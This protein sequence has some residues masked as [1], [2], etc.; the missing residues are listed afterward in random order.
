MNDPIH[1]QSD[2]APQPAAFP[3]YTAPAGAR[4][5]LRD[6]AQFDK[7]DAVAA[8]LLLA[9]G[10]VFVQFML[11][12]PTGLGD[13]AF[14]LLTVGV[15]LCYFRKRGVA[16]NAY[17]RALLAVY[18]VFC[19]VFLLTADSFVR[20]LDAIFLILLG[21]YV[22][23]A[24]CAGR[25]DA[26]GG[27]G[28]DMANALF[29]LPFSGFL[30]SPRAL[31]RGGKSK[32]RTLLYV[33]LGLLAAVPVT[34]AAASLLR[35]ADNG[36][37][38][39]LGR[40]LD[41]IDLDSAA[42][43]IAKLL[44]T[45]AIGFYLFGL[46]Y[47]NASGAEKE[48]LSPAAYAQRRERLHIAPPAFVYAAATPLLLLYAA[49]IALQL[50]YFFSAFAGRLPAGFS[51]AE[52]AR[53]GFFELF[54]VALINLFVILCMGV[55]TCRQADRRPAAL[56]VYT[57]ALSACT[58][59]LLA[60]AFSK[61]ALYIRAYGLTRLRVY[62]AWFMAL[63]ALLLVAVIAKQF[64]PR[65]RAVT[66]MGAVFIVLFGALCFSNVDG[67]IARYNIR[68]Y[69]SGA[70]Q[71]LDVEELMRLSDDAW[72]PMLENYDAVAAAYGSY[73][74][75]L[76]FTDDAGNMFG[77]NEADAV[78]GAPRTFDEVCRDKL[79]YY[80]NNP[81]KTFSLTGLRVKAMLERLRFG[82]KAA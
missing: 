77:Y 75:D 23:F 10:F 35:A 64:A 40:L 31:L 33:A 9:A 16:M 21:A 12:H 27:F 26:E 76:Y 20:T 1:P 62:V 67:V 38:A 41:R 11:W 13:A 74:G 56:T 66:C 32:K 69:V 19:A 18:C 28:L 45:A 48:Q 58:L 30:L 53:R 50:D 44:L 61:M 49:F 68:Q 51:Y 14:F 8:L 73:D 52:Y 34:F 15:C 59:L 29:A 4:R 63:L 3:D 39:M 2:A 81:E 71:T 42:E 79:A 37:D 43:L 57:V 6:A 54:A 65:F 78:E 55:F 82:E 24:A 70:R 47:V 25:G 22:V 7:T 36:F 80:R 72:I 46:L 5:A 60:T 17:Q